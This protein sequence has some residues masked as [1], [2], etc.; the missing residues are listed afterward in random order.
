MRPNYRRQTI[1]HA[2]LVW[3]KMSQMRSNQVLQSLPQQ[4]LF[5]RY[6][7]SLF[8]NIPICNKR[9]KNLFGF[10]W[11]TPVWTHTEPSERCN[12]IATLNR[13]KSSGLR[14]ENHLSEPPSSWLPSSFCLP[15]VK[16]RPANYQDLSTVCRVDLDQS[17]FCFFLLAREINWTRPPRSPL[18]EELLW[19][20][21][22]L[23][24]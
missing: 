8:A 17:V 20:V 12:Q 2:L 13:T 24:Y 6:I 3:I 19:R 16:Q 23:L 15:V 14:C 1:K 10:A 11:E 18:G 21:A 7:C 9:K 5:R 22:A 4:R